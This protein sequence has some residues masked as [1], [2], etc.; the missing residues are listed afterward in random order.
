MYDN[1]RIIIIYFIL[2]LEIIEEIESRFIDFNFL[3]MVLV[4]SVKSTSKIFDAINSNEGFRFFSH[5]FDIFKI[6]SVSY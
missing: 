3:K 4:F 6:E 5:N 2:L 1:R